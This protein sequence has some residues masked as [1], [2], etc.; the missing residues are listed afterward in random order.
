MPHALALIGWMLAVPAHAGF[1]V[2]SFK[3][4]DKLGK[5][6]WDAPSAL[7]SNPETCW[8]VDPEA[9]NVGQWIQIDVPTAEVDKIAMIPGWAASEPTDAFTDHARVKTAKAEIM[10][11][12]TGKVIATYPL[13]FADKAEMQ[14]V[15]IPDTKVGGELSGGRIRITITEVY[16]GQDYPNLAVSEV[17]VHLKEFPAASLSI[18]TP[19]DSE[20]GTNIG[21]N[22]TDGNVKTFWAAEGSTATM[23][24]KAPG[25]GL[26]SISIQSGPKAFARPKTV[27]ITANGTTISR[28][29]PDKPG[30]AQSLLLPALV[31]YTGGA[32]GEV[33]LKIVDV[34]PGDVAANGVA[35]A[36]IK[37]SAGSI[38][39]F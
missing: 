30:I 8:Q 10:D 36:E 25:Y 4:E 14:V 16:K 27:E 7:D 20:A 18:S 33:M 13:A 19:P 32:W 22:A 6:Y 38:E 15:D 34:Y 12:A 31:G 5:S 39:E 1:D 35:I 11:Q 24:L 29:L 9:E 23:G 37:V 3:K 26:A 28:V 21:D 17:L 2:S